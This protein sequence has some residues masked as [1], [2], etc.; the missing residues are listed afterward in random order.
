[1]PGPERAGEMKASKFSEAQIAFIM[2]QAE[3]GAAIGDVGR[4]AGTSDATFDDWRK[5]SGGLPPSEMK[6]LSQD[7]GGH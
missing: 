5:K 2:R 1:M 7:Q 6:R 3:E 4:K